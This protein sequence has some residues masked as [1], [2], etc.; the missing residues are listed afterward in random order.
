MKLA[1]VIVLYNPNI[2]EILNNIDSYIGGVD[3]L[4]VFDNSESN[5][6]YQEKLLEYSNKVRYF[7]FTENMGIAFALNYTCKLAADLGYEWILTMDQDSSFSM[8]SD[9]MVYI[10]HLHSKLDN[11]IALFSPNF[12][13]EKPEAPQFYTSGSLVNLK[14]WESIGK[15][16]ENLFIDEVDGDFSF[17]LKEAN[18]ILIKI[19]NLNLVHALGSKYCITILGKKICSDNHSALRKYYIARNRVYLIKMRPN[20]R[21]LYLADSFRKFVLLLL[22]ENDKIVKLKMIIRGVYHG[23]VNKMGKYSK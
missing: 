2:S 18:Y 20:M 16:D 23:L 5:L 8:P 10:C 6:D 21:R 11:K 9:F 7:S 1:G 4:F 19:H 15:F 3:T 14:A 12:F 13:G 22:I 17:R